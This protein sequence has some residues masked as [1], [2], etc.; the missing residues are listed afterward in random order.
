MIL[1]SYVLVGLN[2]KNIRHYRTKGYEDI[3]VGQKLIVKV[4]DLTKGSHV[5]VNAECTYC[6]KIKKVVY[7]EYNRNVSYNGKF[8]CS[9]VCG[10]IKKKELSLIKYGV[11][12]PSI[13]D[14]IKSKNKK[15][16]LERYGMSSYLKTDEFRTKSKNTMLKKYGVEN[17]M[18]SEV[19]KTKLANSIF[20]K[21]SVL[22]V[23]QSE[24][25]KDKIK[26]VNINKYGFD[27]YSRTDEYKQKY[28][29]TSIEKYGVVSYSL[30]NEYK[31]RIRST[32][33]KRYGVDSY[34]KTSDFKI[35]TTKTLIEKYGTHVLQSNEE[36][37]KENYIISKE[38]EYVRYLGNN[39]SIFKCIREH[40]Y[41]IS[42]SNYFSRKKNNIILCTIC[43]PIGDLTSFKELELYQFIKSIYTGEIKQSYRDKLEIDI[44]LPELNIGFEF[45]GLYY[46][47]NKF[48]EKNYHIN[49]SDFFNERGIRII[50][51]WE[52]DWDLRKEVVKDKIK[53]SIGLYDVEISS[54]ICDI[55][56]VE[57]NTLIKEFLLKNNLKGYIKSSIKIG[58]FLQDELVFL[59]T[60]NKKNND[61]TI[62]NI[63]PRLGY[64]IIGAFDRI[65]D[66]FI[67]STNPKK[68][69]LYDD[70]EDLSNI[71]QGFVLIKRENPKS[72]LRKISEKVKYKV[73]NCG[74]LRY[75]MNIED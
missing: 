62:S 13:L 53:S 59:I 63:C 37:R 75:E 8:S 16:N 26:E 17:P 43:K 64:D 34:M 35:K 68:I 12:S 42:S 58:L 9:N 71:Y 21:F 73:W 30:T 45:N 2:S 14:C 70:I 67:K 18:H 10:S 65:L 31:D 61:W 40:E 72:I 27:S 33:I 4:E 32:C 56:L 48:K 28:Q 52:D 1:D 6:K 66:Y 25:I 24:I 51:V 41:E 50:Y 47:S 57:N 39:V 55:K 44:Y 74:Q 19:F 69:I 23:F 5:L 15:T 11:V 38:E 49:K 60:F 29:K 46:H 54:I 7:R 3:L 20:D 22:N 36:F